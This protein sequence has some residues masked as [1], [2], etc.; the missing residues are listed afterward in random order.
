VFRGVAVTRGAAF[1]PL[2]LVAKGRFDLAL[3][4]ISRNVFYSNDAPYLGHTYLLYPLSSSLAIYF[5]LCGM[6]LHD[7]PTQK[8]A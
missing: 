8:G 7:S 6:C 5:C 1:E 2:R 3:K 4:K